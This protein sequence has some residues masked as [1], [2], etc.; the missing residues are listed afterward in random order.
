MLKNHKIENTGKV[1]KEIQEAW[2]VAYNKQKFAEI[3]FQA[4]IK[5]LPRPKGIPENYRIKI[6]KK[7]SGIIYVHPKH[8]HTYVRVMPG[9]PHSP[10]PYQQKPYVIQKINGKT[11]DKLD[12]LASSEKAIEAHIPIEDFIYRGN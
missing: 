6:S 12:D 5:T 7:G 3:E 9:K 8:N 10:Y 4:G 2:I 11:F 1:N